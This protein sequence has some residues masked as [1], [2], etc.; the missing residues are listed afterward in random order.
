MGIF[1]AVL[2]AVSGYSLLNR[3]LVSSGTHQKIE[4]AMRAATESCDKGYPL[5]LAILMLDDAD[6]NGYARRCEVTGDDVGRHA[7]EVLHNPDLYVFTPDFAENYYVIHRDYFEKACEKPSA[8][9]RLKTFFSDT[10]YDVR[11]HT[12][13]DPASPF[14]TKSYGNSF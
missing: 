4:S 12:S 10:F 8:Y 5:R 9:C 1:I 6:L 2:I 7:N 3:S 11:L 13:G 14:I